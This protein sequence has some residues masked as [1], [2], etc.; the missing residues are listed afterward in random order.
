MSWNCSGSRRSDL[1]P[2][3]ARTSCRI[4]SSSRGIGLLER[5]LEVITL[6]LQ[7]IALVVQS[8]ECF[9]PLRHQNQ[10]CPVVDEQLHPVRAARAEHE[11]VAGE[12]VQAQRDL[13][14]GRQT[15]HAA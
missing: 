14:Q 6:A 13:H 3:W 12:R 15:I 9:Q 1:R 8:I 10:T 2:N 4:T 11:D 5:T 7:A